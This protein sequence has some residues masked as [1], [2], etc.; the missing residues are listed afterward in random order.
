MT[1]TGSYITLHGGINTY[2]APFHLKNQISIPLEDINTF[3]LSHM[4][5]KYLQKSRRHWMKDP[6]VL[7][8]VAAA[9]RSQS[10]NITFLEPCRVKKKKLSLESDFIFCSGLLSLF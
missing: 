7:C 1:M 3:N 5:G 9:G 8:K 6:P 10:L 4:E 2:T